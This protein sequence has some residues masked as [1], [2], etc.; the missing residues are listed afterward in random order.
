MKI[1]R[2]SLQTGCGRVLLTGLI[3]SWAL[4]IAPSMGMGQDPPP[5]PGP[6]DEEPPG[7]QV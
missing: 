4:A 6:A 1:S 2:T 3:L 7:G 5:P